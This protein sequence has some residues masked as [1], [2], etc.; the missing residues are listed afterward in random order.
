MDFV[1]TLNH[2]ATN[3]YQRISVFSLT[4][5]QAFLAST[6]I[7]EMNG[8]TDAVAAYS[9]GCG[10]GAVVGVS[11]FKHLAKKRQKTK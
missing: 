11:L 5:L 4:F 10:L 9:F 2:L 8:K 3:Q 1:A 6:M 7:I